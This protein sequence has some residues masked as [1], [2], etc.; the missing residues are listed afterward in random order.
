MLTIGQITYANCTP[1]FHELLKSCPEGRYRLERGVPAVLNEKLRQG[2]IDLC[3]SSSIEYGRRAE[4]Y[5]LLPDLSISAVG[6]VKSV[7]LFSRLPLEEL[8]G[9]TVGLTSESETSV[10]LLRILLERYHGVA[11]SFE[12]TSGLDLDRYPACLL[13]GD[14]A[15]KAVP[16]Q[17]NVHCFD[18][19]ALWHEATGL[20]FVFALWIVR[21]EAVERHHEALKSLLA[22]VI[23]AKQRA[24]LSYE[25]I[26]ENSQEST[27][28]DRKE[29]VDYWR[30]ISYD[31]TPAHQQ[32]VLRFFQDARDLG[33]L[34]AVPEL[35]FVT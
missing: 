33:I 7:L 27:W 6:P 34:S 32:G 19:G 18:L 8:A 26:A 15:L 28:M 12:P 2:E 24:L 22:D 35:R 13:I 10:V 25:D 31:L 1:I 9:Q 20:P 4:R 30:T 14:A 11:A 16:A 29:L 21:Q 23:A 17:R 5:Y 3:P